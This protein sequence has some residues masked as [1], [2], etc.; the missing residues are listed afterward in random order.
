MFAMEQNILI[1]CTFSRAFCIKKA[2]ALKQE[3]T[4]SWS[5]CGKAFVNRLKH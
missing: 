2:Y 3:D 4:R 5:A 1:Y